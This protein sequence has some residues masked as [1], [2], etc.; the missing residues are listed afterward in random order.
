METVTSCL[1]WNANIYKFVWNGTF[2]TT[3]EENENIHNL[4]RMKLNHSQLVYT[5]METFTTYFK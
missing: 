4:F 5:D 1:E 2:A 3:L